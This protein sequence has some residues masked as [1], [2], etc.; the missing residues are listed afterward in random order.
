[1]IACSYHTGKNK[2]PEGFRVMDINTGQ[3]MDVTYAALYNVI[4]SK[5]AIVVNVE[6]DGNKLKGSNG[7][8]DRYPK[9]VGGKLR[10]ESKMIV[11]KELGTIGYEVCDHTG[12]I[13]RFSIADAIK[14]ADSFG[15]ANGKLVKM[16][17]GTTYISPIS[18]EY[19]KL[20]DEEVA[21]IFG[22]RAV[23]KAK[24]QQE[25]HNKAVQAQQAAKTPVGQVPSIQNGRDLSK[26]TVE[27]P[28]VV[29]HTQP[30]KQTEQQKQVEVVKQPEP[31][32]Q[33][34]LQPKTTKKEVEVAVIDTSANKD[35]LERAK[36][37][38]LPA[39]KGTEVS[40]KHS[41]LKNVCEDGTG[42][43]VE[44]KITRAGLF[45]KSTRSFY[46]AILQTIKQ[47]E[48]VEIPTM[49]VSID[50]LYYN[51]DFVSELQLPELVFV[52]IH[53]LL[54][55][56]MR[57]NTRRAQRD[58]E[59]WNIACDLYINKVI[60]DEFAINPE[61]KVA[62]TGIPED[63]YNIG[64]K[65]AT[66]GLYSPKIDIN[67]DTPESIYAEMEKESESQT[68]QMQMG[69]PGQ[70]QQGQDGQG[71]QSQN[72]QG[73]GQQGQQGQ[74]GQQGQGQNQ[75]GQG[76]G[77]D[78]DGQ[79]QSGQGQTGQNQQGNQNGQSGNGGQ[80]GQ[81]GD[82]GQSSGGITIDV[83]KKDY[84]F[85]GDHITS[86]TSASIGGVGDLIDDD[87]SRSASDTT[88]KSVYDS[89]MKKAKVLERQMQ[90]GKGKGHYGV[91]EA[92]VD[93][94]LVPK[95]NWRN[96]LMNRLI[97]MKSDEKSLSTPDRRF[98]SRGLYIEGH[99]EEDELLKDIK[100]CI[101]TS[102]SMSD[103][104]I[105]VAFVQ[106]KQLLKTYKTEAEIV[107]WDDGIQDVVPFEDYNGLRLAQLR[108]TGRGGTNPN[109]IFELFTSKDYKIGKKAKPELIVIFTDG[110]FGGPS[111]QYKARFGRDVLWVISGQN[112]G[113][114]PPFGKI[115]K[116]K[117]T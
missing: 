65:F 104:D 107:Y 82:P 101:D 68:Q 36:K 64:I 30:V 117:E 89:I 53:E 109:C 81:M 6:V 112:K 10:G 12:R 18:G 7:T 77:Q 63:T 17:N 108:A 84:K 57:H 58:P 114:N 96:V 69:Q 97:Q 102:G 75:Q 67:K 92:Y 1:M 85:R 26:E 51:S 74:S 5:Q 40:G 76:Q 8:F 61:D 59:L 98:V 22:K 39:I 86:S 42:L 115:A 52:E 15:V 49:A 56:A 87:K 28:K 27:Q 55:I 32:K 9:L 44:Q 116:L 99:R 20:T 14:C 71:Q 38:K 93:E 29:T 94:E 2:E 103:E 80:S 111:E 47:K 73:Q 23:N 79:G 13:Q 35:Y 106:I 41:K 37:N 48:S 45:V 83:T 105:A 78:G 66:G 46:Y 31:V 50:T 33:A 16:A 24:A 54:H 88:K 70:G 90:A 3:V 4:K 72:Q 91:V 113:F 60:C 110:Y 21:K 62:K 25:A 43:T 11:M 34:P 100:L 95:V 19:P